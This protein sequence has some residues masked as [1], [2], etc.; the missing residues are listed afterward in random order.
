MGKKTL[1]S[2][3][4]TGLIKAKPKKKDISLESVSGDADKKWSIGCHAKPMY[5][6]G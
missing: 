6:F 2:N 5:E 3:I 4:S 1:L